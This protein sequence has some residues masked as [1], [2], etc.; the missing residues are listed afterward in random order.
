MFRM[1]LYKYIRSNYMIKRNP[2]DF[3]RDIG[4]R[5][6]EN[7]RF[8]GLTRGTFG[9]EPFLVTIGNHVTIT[10]GVRFITHDGGVWIFREETPNIDVFGPIQIGNNVFIGLN[11]T[12]MPNIKIGDN[13]VVGAGSIVTKDV[14][15]NSVVAG[16]PARIISTVDSYKTSVKGKAMYIRSSSQEEKRKI[17]KEYF[18]GNST[19]K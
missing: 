1:N 5:V 10:G 19:A 6:G 3:A 18:L 15:N 9:S 2:V 14:P 12:I 7:C 13:V 17:L 11:A 8:L 16:I 4:V